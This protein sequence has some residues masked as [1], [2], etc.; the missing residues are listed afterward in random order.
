MALD[1]AYFDSINIDVAKKKYYNVNKVEAVLADIRREAEA[2][3]AENAE[4]QKQ[5]ELLSGE[6]SAIG[7]VLV[8]ARNAAEKIMT[9][10]DRRA[11]AKLR[12]AEARAAAMLAETEQKCKIMLDEAKRQENHAVRCVEETY[13]RLKEMQIAAVARLNDDYQDF[14]CRLYP[15]PEDEG[16]QEI[17]AD[18]SDKVSAIADELFSI[19]NEE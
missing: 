7:D 14:L 18:L 2:L 1:K 5:V 17:P 6:K 10:A 11:E 13:R 15:E 9:D 4:L 19:G 8:S 12:D 3:N 16:K